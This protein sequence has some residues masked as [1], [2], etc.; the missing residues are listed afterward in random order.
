LR[1]GLGHK[2]SLKPPLFIEVP[3][4]K[5]AIMYLCVRGIDFAFLYD[6]DFLLWN[7]SDIVVFFKYNLTS[8]SFPHS[9]LITGCVTRLTRWVPLVEQELFILPEHL[10]SPS[11]L[12]WA[13]VTRSIV[14]YNP[15]LINGTFVWLDILPYFIELLF[16]YT[17]VH[18]GK[19]FK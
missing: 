4:P 2:T 5:W 14:Y 18:H 1:L 13:C 11:V 7:C 10:R 16:P 17:G 8:R 12:S 15:L 19:C 6:F 9:W 3:I